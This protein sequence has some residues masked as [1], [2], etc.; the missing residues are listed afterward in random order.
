MM[1][2]PNKQGTLDVRGRS[3]LFA[4]IG[5]LISKASAQAAETAAGPEGEL[6]SLRLRLNSVMHRYRLLCDHYASLAPNCSAT[7]FNCTE[8]PEGWLHFADKCYFLSTDKMDWSNSTDRCTE[9]GSHLAILHTK[10]QHEALEKEA[11]RIGG[12]NSYYWIGL[13]DTENEDQWRWVDNTTLHNQYWNTWYKQPDNHPSAGTE[14][15][16]CVVL[17]SHS[18]TWYDVPCS[19]TYPR[20]CQMDAMQLH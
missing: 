19:F 2:F 8:C 11:I 12:F 16:D 3:V 9:M 18:Q 4:L 14:G 10:E 17:D 1:N 5:L 13:T 20:I 15:E 6:S 7:V